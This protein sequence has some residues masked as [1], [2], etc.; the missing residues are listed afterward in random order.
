MTTM[1]KH[2]CSSLDSQMSTTVEPLIHLWLL[3]ILIPL[4]GHRKFIGGRSFD[5]DIL[6]DVLGL[7]NWIDPDDGDYES[8][9]VRK[10]LRMLHK[11]AERKLHDSTVSLCLAENIKQLSTLV[12]LSDVDCRL[13]EFVVIIN[14][15]QLLDDTA[16]MLGDLSSVKMFHILSVLLNLPEN[17]IKS[18]LSPKSILAKSGLVSVDRSNLNAIGRKFDLLSDNFADYISSSVVD[19]VTLLRDTVSLS[20]PPQLKIEDYDHIE[21]ELK[22]VRPYLKKSSAS[23]RIGVNI[24]FHGVPGTGKSQLARVL[25]EEIGCTLFEVSSENENGEP[26]KG[27]RRL[28]AFS[29]AQS[30]F[31]KRKALI[32]FDEVEDIFDDGEDIWG[33]KTTAQTRK[34]WMNRTLEENPIPT[35][36]ITNS[37]YNMD[38]A[39]IRRFDMVIELPVPR[40]KHRQH[41]LNEI[42][43]DFLDERNIERISQ[44]EKLSPAVITRAAS[45]VR[46]INSELGEEGKSSAFELIINNTL[47]TQGH[48]PI[49][50]NDPNQLPEVY[51]PNFIQSDTNI[52]ELASG[53]IKTKAGRLCFYGPPGTGKT[54]Y[55]RWLSDKLDMPL[56]VKCASDLISMWVGQSEKNVARAFREAE[57]DGAILLID[58]VDSFLQDRRGAKNSW[59]ITL[60][61]EMLTQM[62]SFAGIFIA[63]TNLMEGLDQASLRRFDLKIKFDYM[64]IDQAWNLLRK[65]CVMLDISEPK[66]TLKPSIDLL[67]NLTPGDFA[68][69]ARRHRFQPITSAV[70]MVDALNAECVLKGGVQR[71]I[72][73]H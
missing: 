61:N 43:S 18:S 1:N 25:A 67:S 41:I 58:E 69:V 20:S 42:C 22:I 45:V 38:P 72:G 68:T 33:K 27:E 32:L 49:R 35:L 47:E 51:D 52:A 6:A 30:F 44:S 34:A 59:D 23:N 57:L 4:G 7:G 53:L 54:A 10:E 19:P 26:V 36:W 2:R 71:K 73:F 9:T 8:K 31:A 5:N 14:T 12:G 46:S 15:E 21:T 64:S 24:L 63:S 66:N 28:R 16:D 17:D 62:E 3:R 40:K 50:R 55:G 29:A 37:T 70:S 39:F 60:V 56:N 65:Y 48:K 11:R 13:L